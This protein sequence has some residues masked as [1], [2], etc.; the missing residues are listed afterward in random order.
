MKTTTLSILTNKEQPKKVRSRRRWDQAIK[1]N[2]TRLILVIAC[3][4]V[5][6]P[7]IWLVMASFSAGTSLYSSSLIPQKITLDNYLNLFSGID[8]L[9][10]MKNSL[11]ICT[12]SST[13]TLFFTTTMAFAF[14]RFRF[15]G[16]RVGLLFLILIQ[17]FPAVMSIVAI[18]R[19]L[20]VLHLL[21]S[22][23]GLILIYGGTGIA[24]STY[25]LKGFIDSLPKEIDESAYIDGAS[26]WQV[27]TRII[28]PLASPMLAVVFLFSFIGFYQE[29]L[30]ASVVLSSPNLRPIALGLRF[31]I[32]GNY[33]QNWTGFAAAS[34]VASLPVM[35]IFFVLQ[36][37]LITGLTRGALKG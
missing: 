4:L 29:Y 11:I 5:L 31:F 30:I 22:Q 1:L 37:Y 27:F 24:F 8:F 10:W 36:R 19:L 15:L 18:F 23:L 33:A 26:H 6:F 14:S 20:Q 28:L 32:N 21:D 7:A 12:C 2:F 9:M 35:I 16:R 17:M 3:L 34:I 13:L 25:L